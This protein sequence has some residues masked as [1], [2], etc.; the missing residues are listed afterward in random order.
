MN[1]YNQDKIKKENIMGTNTLKKIFIAGAMALGFTVMNFDDAAA[2]TFKDMTVKQEQK[3]EQ[4]VQFDLSHAEKLA[5][6]AAQGL[7]GTVTIP[8]YE[9]QI[10]VPEHLKRY[11]NISVVQ[12]M[13]EFLNAKTTEDFSGYN[14]FDMLEI[15]NSRGLPDFLSFENRLLTMKNNLD[16]ISKESLVELSLITGIDYRNST[17]PYDSTPSEHL[18]IYQKIVEAKAN[19][20]ERNFNHPQMQQL[21]E[22]LHMNI[23]I[24]NEEIK[25][26]TVISP[27]LQE[28][29]EDTIG[30]SISDV[31]HLSATSS[32]RYES[33]IGQNEPIYISGYNPEEIS[34]MSI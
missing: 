21:A 25:G 24:F 4:Q 12:Q 31:Q 29:F 17:L 26:D 8:E 15:H 34:S 20:I 13:D 18:K 5:Q 14:Q 28:R 22:L 30:M 32:I 11:E 27:Q 10:Q 33:G 2:Q 7:H 3:M 6:M 19:L 9:K 1:T 23:V 16:K